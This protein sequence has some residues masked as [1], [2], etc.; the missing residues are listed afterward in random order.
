MQPENPAYRERRLER[1]EEGQSQATHT[2]P[3]D[4]DT[5]QRWRLLRLVFPSASF[6]A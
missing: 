6:V 3:G 2:E 5:G 4:V 1:R